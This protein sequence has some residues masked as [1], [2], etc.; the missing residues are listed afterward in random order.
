MLGTT[1][2]KDG[3]DWV[4]DGHKWFS[5]S[6][7]G[8]AFAIC[9]AV[10]NP[11]RRAA[12]P[13]EHDPR[14]DRR[15]PASG[16]CATSPSWDTPAATGR[17][18]PRSRYESARV[19]SETSSAAR[20]WASSSRSSASAPAASTTACDGSAS[21]SGRST[22]SAVA[23]RTR[24]I[25]PGKPLGT[26]QIVQAVDRREP[27]RDPRRAPDGPSRRLEDRRGGARRPRGDLAHQVHRRRT[28]AARRRPRHPGARRPG[29]DR[30]DAARV[31]V[32]PRAC[33]AHLRRRPTRSTSSRSPSGSSAG[34]GSARGS[35]LLDGI[36]LLRAKRK[37]FRS[38]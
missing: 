33:R 15:R 19:P 24:E 32:R 37:T 27:R 3:G 35:R 8:S 18:T 7:D 9:M 25:A 22:S 28:A 16:S 38:R 23:P 30:R 14:A 29:D 34:T 17:A 12:R 2:R 11:E 20:A 31:L 6:M 26:E 1:A 36:P 5:S 21:A 10:T 13:R 4:I